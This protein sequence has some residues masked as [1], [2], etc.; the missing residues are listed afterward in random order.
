MKKDAKV[1]DMLQ[2]QINNLI[3]KNLKLEKENKALKQEVENLNN[4]ILNK[5]LAEVEF[6]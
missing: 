5:E 3:D 6:G 4:E 2:K 1:I